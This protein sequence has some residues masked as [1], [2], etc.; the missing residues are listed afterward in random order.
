ML[1]HLADMAWGQPLQRRYSKRQVLIEPN[2]PY[3]ADALKRVSGVQVWDE[4]EPRT[5]WAEAN[6][7][8]ARMQA[9]GLRTGMGV[10]DP[11]WWSAW[12]WWQHPRAAAFVDGEFLKLGYYVGR[13]RFGV[14]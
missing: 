8:R 1:L 5:S 2:A 10:S 3:L 9:Q 11:P 12:R 4:F 6:H 7:V 13:Y 14:L